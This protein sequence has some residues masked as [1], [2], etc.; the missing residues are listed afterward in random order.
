MGTTFHPLSHRGNTAVYFVPARR[1]TNNDRTVQRYGRHGPQRIPSP[2]DLPIKPAQQRLR[3]R[4]WVGNSPS[5][6]I[7][8][9][10]LHSSKR[11]LIQMGGER[12]P[13]GEHRRASCCL[14]AKRDRPLPGKASYWISS[15][16]ALRSI[17]PTS[18][19][20]NRA[21]SSLRLLALLSLLPT[22]P[23]YRATK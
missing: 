11:N 1:A 3:K 12:S 19:Q 18:C 21:K 13:L 5:G 7:D 6:V 15:D 22:R 17:V 8:R 16:A 20:R 10:T 9:A 23:L 2:G 14:S 4:N